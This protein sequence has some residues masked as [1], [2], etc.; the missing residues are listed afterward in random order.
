[1]KNRRHGTPSELFSLIPD[2]E[3]FSDVRE[4]TAEEEALHIV[5]V[6]RRVLDDP[7][8]SE[9]DRGDVDGK[10]PHYRYEDEEPEVDDPDRWQS[11]DDDETPDCEELLVVQHYAFEEDAALDDD[12][13]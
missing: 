4:R 1:M 9:V 3:P 10:P 5:R 7:G 6:A 12:A 8:R 13:S 11:L 2:D